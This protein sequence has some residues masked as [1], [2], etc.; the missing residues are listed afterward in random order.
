MTKYRIKVVTYA[1]NR[2]LYIPQYRYWYLFWLDCRH[3]GEVVECTSETSAKMWI[4]RQLTAE[5]AAIAD[6]TI[7]ETKIIVDVP[8]EQ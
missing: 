7:T 6:R 8:Q 2:T 5:A 3:R 4:K 1:N